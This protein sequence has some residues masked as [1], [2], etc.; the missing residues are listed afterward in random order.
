MISDSIK[1]GHFFFTQI[2]IQNISL[3]AHYGK[4]QIN[5]LL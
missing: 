1:E 2:H 3:F 4:A 5:K